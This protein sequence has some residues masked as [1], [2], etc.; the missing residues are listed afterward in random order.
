MTRFTV[1]T[2]P[3]SPFARAVMAMLIEK[4]ADWRIAP[5]VPGQHKA[6]PYLSLQPLGKMPALEWDDGVLYETQAIL[7]YL[8]E[9]L[10]GPSFTPSTIDDR[11]RVNQCIGVCDCYLF[12]EAAGPIVFQ[13]VVGPA[14]ARLVPD[15]AVVA[16]AMPRAHIIFAELSRLLADRIWFGGDSPS[17]A[18]LMLGPQLELFSRAP[19]WSELIQDR[20]NLRAWL[21]RV[22]ARP[23]MKATLWER[24]PDLIARQKLCQ[25]AAGRDREVLTISD[26][27][28]EDRAAVAASRSPSET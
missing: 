3:G 10:P 23:S 14:I 22:E 17:I 11:A 5:L 25:K 28:G 7:R 2:V 27:T 20:A 26:F 18:D 8:D 4:G 15:E 19:E 16:T 1:H 13:R 21:D 12:P 24:L 9:A 6:E